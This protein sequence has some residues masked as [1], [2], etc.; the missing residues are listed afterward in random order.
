M[1]RPEQPAVLTAP[2]EAAS[3]EAL[4]G[5]GLLS[6]DDAR[7]FLGGMSRA[8][9]YKLMAAGALP[10]VAAGRRR[11]IPVAALR[12]YAAARLRGGVPT[13]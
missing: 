10:W 1:R 3:P 2:G 8:F 9:L 4:V 7:R 6:V 5:E 13:S 11:L 12:A